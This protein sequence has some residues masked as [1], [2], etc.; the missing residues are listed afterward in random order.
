M[1]PDEIIELFSNLNI[2]RLG[3]K[4]APNK[5]LL[6]LFA[7]GK[8]QSENTKRLSFAK[9]EDS[10]RNLLQEFGTTGNV[11]TG[12]ENAFYRLKKDA[13]GSIWRVIARSGVLAPGSSGDQIDLSYLNT[14]FEL[15][16]SYHL[17]QIVEAA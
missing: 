6:I 1:T 9:C 7:L 15:Y 13:S 14:V 17:G 12:P 2:W 10:Y 8:L 16:S 11:R 3:D 5:P 4:R